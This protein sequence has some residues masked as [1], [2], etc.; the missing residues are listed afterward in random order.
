MG[1]TSSSDAAA[2]PSQLPH[3]QR[4]GFAPKAQQSDDA[5][6]ASATSGSTLSAGESDHE[7][8]AD[9]SLRLVDRAFVRGRSPVR[10]VVFDCDE[11]LTLATLLPRVLSAERLRRSAELSFESPW[12]PNRLELLSQLLETLAKDRTLAVLTRNAGGLEPVLRLLQAAGLDQHFSAVWCA[13]LGSERGA[14]R[15]NG[16]WSYFTPPCDVEEKPDIL[17]SICEAPDSWFPGAS[18]GLHGLADAEVVLVD[19]RPQN[20]ESM[21]GRRVARFCEVPRFEARFRHMGNVTLGGL[22]AR[23]EVDFGQLLRFVETPWH[24]RA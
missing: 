10:L 21:S 15:K 5:S 14:V 19:D 1:C 12:Y 2:F 6:T 18:H 17:H 8:A 24:F 9:E 22:G 20:F 3:L 4:T 23:S 13:P 7:T 16:E 11:T